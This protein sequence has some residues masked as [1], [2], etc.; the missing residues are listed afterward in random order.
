MLLK[1]VLAGLFIQAFTLASAEARVI[2]PIDDRVL[3]SDFEADPNLESKLALRSGLTITEEYRKL[4]WGAVGVIVCNNEMITTTNVSASTTTALSTRMASA[5][6]IG[7]N[8]RVTTTLHTFVQTDLDSCIFKNFYGQQSAIEFSQADQAKIRNYRKDSPIGTDQITVALREEIAAKPF[9][10][11][12][13]P[14]MD[15]EEFYGVTAYE[16]DINV[17]SAMTS[18]ILRKAVAQGIQYD[19]ERGQLGFISDADFSH[20]GSGGVNLFQRGERLVAKGI[21]QGLSIAID[22]VAI[23]DREPFDPERNYIL[24]TTFR[25]GQ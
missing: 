17:D 10:A 13:S 9:E 16:D 23:M 19:F 4:I 8:R 18:P 20:G 12:N 7:S 21:F 5:A 25:T 3:T 24:S 15:G 14:V 11:D 22:D 6:L 1:V 2:G